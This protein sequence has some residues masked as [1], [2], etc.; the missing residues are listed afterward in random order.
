MRRV[1]AL[2]C[3]FCVIACPAISSSTPVSQ[4]SIPIEKIHSNEVLPKKISSLK[5]RDLERL[6]GRKFTIKEKIA[7]LILKKKLKHQEDTNNR[8][9]KTAFS[10]GI[11]AVAL[12]LLG[13]FVPYVIFGS[14]VAAIVAIVM[15][16]SAAKKDPTD[17]KAHSAKLLGWITLGLIALLIIVIAAVVAAWAW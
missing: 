17:R 1:F 12:L 4:L 11:A 3:L 13:L 10:F 7:F 8:E 2:L 5:V 9:G 14:L 15:G 6:A 16:S